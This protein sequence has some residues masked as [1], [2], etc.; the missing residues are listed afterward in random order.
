MRFL[1]ASSMKIASKIEDSERNFVLQLGRARYLQNYTVCNAV[2]IQK[3]TM[4]WMAKFR[5]C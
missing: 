5:C 1:P 2:Y 4:K 3:E